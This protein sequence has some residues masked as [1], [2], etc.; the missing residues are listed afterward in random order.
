[1]LQIEVE[2]PEKINIDILFVNVEGRAD[3]LAHLKNG[4]L[5]FLSLLIP[6]AYNTLHFKDGFRTLENIKLE[7]QIGRGSRN[8]ER[9]S[10]IK[11][12]LN[13]AGIIETRRAVSKIKSAGYRIRSE[14]L[15]GPFKTY[16]LSREISKR[17]LAYE[18]IKSV[19]T[20]S[21]LES[22]YRI[23]TDQFKIHTIHIDASKAKRFLRKITKE[24]LNS[25]TGKKLENIKPK[26]YFFLG[27]L[28]KKIDDLNSGKFQLSVAQ[29]NRRLNS[30]ITSL[31]RILRPFLRIN[32]EPIGEIDIG[33]AQ[34]LL[35]STLLR[36]ERD[37]VENSIFSIEKV[38]PELQSEIQKKYPA[39]TE[40]IAGIPLSRDQVGGLGSFLDFNFGNDFYL[41]LINITDQED[42][43]M[44]RK[45][46]KD[47][48]MYW[49]FDDNHTA[50]KNNKSLKYF[51]RKYTELNHFL[52][53]FHG[54]YSNRQ[55]ALLLHRLEINLIIRVCKSI[56]SS[57][58]LIP[59][60]TIHDCVITTSKYT[61]QVNEIM[62]AE[63]ENICSREVRLQRINQIKSEPIP[64]VVIELKK[65]I[66]SKAYSKLLNSKLILIGEQFMN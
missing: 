48:I 23:F 21:L 36:M 17:L 5:Y 57:N 19:A 61:K 14:Y 33:N 53:S 16:L 42:P 38:Y 29:S 3:Y 58:S 37:V 62:K 47:N 66:N 45:R 4:A 59:F 43:I 1:M 27:D 40:L 34:I 52:E 44:A 9:V 56:K 26:L 8:S 55:L 49:L 6:D 25:Y 65:K 12:A 35:L 20:E 15:D 63:L 39:Q 22:H 54:T 10:V 7:K 31:P 2:I 18:K 30:V 46:V 11:N 64:E 51:S 60:F 32:G 24:V 28:K 13:N 41:S 50:R